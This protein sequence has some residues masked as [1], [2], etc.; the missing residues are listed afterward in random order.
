MLKSGIEDDMFRIM[1]VARR[2]DILDCISIHMGF[3][4][5]ME[6]DESTDFEVFTSKVEAELNKLRHPTT[7]VTQHMSIAVAEMNPLN[8]VLVTVPNS[9]TRHVRTYK[10]DNWNR[11]CGMNDMMRGHDIEQK[12]PVRD[13]TMFVLCNGSHYMPI[14]FLNTDLNASPDNRIIQS[15]PSWER[16]KWAMRV[17]KYWGFPERTIRSINNRFSRRNC[18]YEGWCSLV[19]GHSGDHQSN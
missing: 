14:W 6:V 12:E 5:M 4:N 13:R 9:W 3:E 11:M 17:A 8:V 16:A 1:V 15:V 7:W 18:G 19:L 2:R 10:D